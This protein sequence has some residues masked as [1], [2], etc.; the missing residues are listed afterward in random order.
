MNEEI[1]LI[2]LGDAMVE[3]KAKVGP[4]R[5]NAAQPDIKGFE[6]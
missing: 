2:D 4:L 5:D 1:T 3:T 6:D